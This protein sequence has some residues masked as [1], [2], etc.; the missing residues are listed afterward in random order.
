MNRTLKVQRLPTTSARRGEV[1][2]AT[3][4]T[5]PERGLV[6][7]PAAPLLAAALTRG[8][9]APGSGWRVRLAPVTAGEG[10]GVLVAVSYL[11]R[12]GRPAGFG[13]AT[14]RD[15]PES[16]AAAEREVA[17]WSRALRSRRMLIADADPM[18]WGARRAGKM[19][20]DATAP[21]Y[22]AED[23]YGADAV[24][25]LA[26]VSDGG[27]VAFPAHGTALA[28]QAE[29]AA[30][31]L[32]V[33]DGTC[34]LVDTAQADIR[35]Y[36]DRGDTVV[37]VGRAGHAVASSLAGQAPEAVV[38]VQDIAD[39]AALT[40]IDGDRVSFVL[41]TGVPVEE[42]APIVAALRARYPHLRGHHFDA[43][44]YA[45]SDRAETV[46]SVAAAC[47]LTL[48]L[49]TA[50]DH[51]TGNMASVAASAGPEPHIV[52]SAGDLDASWMADAGTIGL[53]SAR[54]APP[55]L[56]GEMITVLSGLGPL[57]VAT[58]RVATQ[59]AHPAAIADLAGQR[60]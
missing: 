43:S 4:F 22:E 30:R 23:W 7:C 38:L 53:V 29:A 41:Q 18:C 20:T 57:S 52:N 54:S 42:T 1:I 59:I 15:D 17:G 48:V 31:G 5:H 49:G 12:E 56:A 45:A 32:Q 10:P 35:R 44:C 6:P 24:T 27:R 40:G 14:H 13:V 37:L 26:Q 9:E 46:R 55:S 3:G 47:D 11:D 16:L 19:I 58:R 21:V 34:P 36:A 39:V 25:D 60:T 28:I 51:D 2:A 50:S 33:T 8:S